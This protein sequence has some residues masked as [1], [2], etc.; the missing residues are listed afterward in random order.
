MWMWPSRKAAVVMHTTLQHT[1]STV[2]F[3]TMQLVGNN[4]AFSALRRLSVWL[5]RNSIE[6]VQHYTP[7]ASK[8]SRG[9]YFQVAWV[10]PGTESSTGEIETPRFHRMIA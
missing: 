1:V 9:R 4:S 5:P 6:P 8:I 2:L 7:A 3:S 10:K